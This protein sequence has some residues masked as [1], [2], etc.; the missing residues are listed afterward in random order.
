[1]IVQYKTSGS[2]V[3]QTSTGACL[4]VGLPP[5]QTKFFPD[6][7]FTDWYHVLLTEDILRKIIDHGLDT[8][9]KIEPGC[10]GPNHICIFVRSSDNGLRA[11]WLKITRAKTANDEA[12]VKRLFVRTTKKLLAENGFKQRLL[13]L[14]RWTGL[15]NIPDDLTYLIAEHIHPKE[16]SLTV[17]PSMQEFVKSRPS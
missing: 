4:E 1:M 17:K 16:S 14:N 12:E 3:L 9:V 11:Y 6:H 15:I 8:S 13:T 7:Y 10:E 2:D 5:G